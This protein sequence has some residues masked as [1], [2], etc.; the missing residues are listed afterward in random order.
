M[1]LKPVW[2]AV[3]V[4][5]V[6]AA[7]VEAV[8]FQ[9]DRTNAK[10]DAATPKL[11]PEELRETL[12]VA[13][14]FIK[15]FR[16]S[17]DMSP[18]IKQMFARGFDR[19]IA[20]DSSWAGLVGLP[21][22]LI[23]HLNQSERVRCYSAHFSIEYIMRLYLFGKVPLDSKSTEPSGSILPPEVVRFFES[24]RPPEIEVRTEEEARRTL[25]IFERTVTF[26]RNHLVASPPEETDQFKRNLAAFEKHLDDPENNVGRPK[27]RISGQEVAG[28][29]A[30][31]RLIVLEIPFHVALLLVR[32]DG[33]LKILFAISQ[34]P[35]D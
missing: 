25:A 24:N 9:A 8:L 14:L 29:P 3:L 27:L 2:C 19:F 4:L 26:L 34:I 11:T 28:Y 7:P 17:R 22:P 31:T 35:P 20:A 33:E 15:R 1:H 21:F 23:E 6:G 5:M 12:A 30:G 10:Q 16:E 18:I 13:D 32:E